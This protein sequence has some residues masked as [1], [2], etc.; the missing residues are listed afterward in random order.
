MEAA[1]KTDPTRQR[2]ES[3]RRERLR[4]E[5]N[6]ERLLIA[7]QEGLVSLEEL[8]KRIPHLR[9]QEH[10]VQSELKSIEMAASDES[11]YLRLTE[12][13]ADFHTRLRARAEGMD[14][15]ERQRIIRL[16]VKE[17]QPAVL[18]GAGHSPEFLAVGDFNGDA[19]P[20]LAVANSNSNT[21][22]VLLNN[23]P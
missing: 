11:M 3:L 21:V 10:A 8:R 17:I 19:R 16:L 2:E 4:M 15:R 13:L 20:D 6:I 18:F 14:V 5:K 22:S 12:T 23:I 7:Y 9:K 1:Q